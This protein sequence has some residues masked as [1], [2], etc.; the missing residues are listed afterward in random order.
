MVLV[1]AQEQKKRT[2]LVFGAN[3]VVGSQVLNAI[4]DN[5]DSFWTKVILVGRRFPPS[6][7]PGDSDADKFKDDDPSEKEHRGGRRPEIVKIQLS[8]LTD[9]HEK[10][11]D[12]FGSKEENDEGET[13][14]ACF[15]ALG[16]SNPFDYDLKY[17]HSIEVEMIASITKLCN[18]INGSGRGV[19]YIGLLST[20]DAEEDPKPFSVQ[21]L[22]GTN[23][24]GKTLGWWGMLKHY[25]RIKGL[26][27]AA[28]VEGSKDISFVSLFQSCS[29]ITKESRYGC[30]DKTIFA[31]H[32]L[33]DPI[34]PKQYHS[35]KDEMLGKAFV[36]DAVQVLSGVTSEAREKNKVAKLTY[37]DFLKI[38][39]GKGAEEKE[40]L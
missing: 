4:L 40:E 34:L 16:V 11:E 6:L 1:R 15:I 26:Q 36:F 13:I 8:D 21:E 14:D 39:D 25:Y 3:G 33:F 17:W 7:I 35:V 27:E 18:Q 29:I 22:S 24:K 19:K 31:F 23:D 38:V 30:I 5:T 10:R 9:I 12:L 32:R 2:A 28:V 37:V 20:I